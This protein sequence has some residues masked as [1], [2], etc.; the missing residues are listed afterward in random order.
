[1]YIYSWDGGGICI[2]ILQLDES[3][4]GRLSWYY[5]MMNITILRQTLL[6]ILILRRYIDNENDF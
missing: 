3:G 4:E 6:L 5:S 1:M 2:R